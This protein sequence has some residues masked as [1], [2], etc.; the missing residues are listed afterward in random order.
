MSTTTTPEWPAAKVR[1]VFID[2]F[3]N[4]GHTFVPSSSTIPYEDPTLLFANAG[5]NQYKS[6]FLGTVDPNSDFAKLKRAV[7]SQKCIRA[8]GKH[9]DLEDVGKDT[10]HHTMFE[11]LGNW[12]FGDYFKK[13]AILW[14]WELLTEVYKLPKDRLYVTYFEGDAKQGL[15]PD[16]E[17]KQLW[18]DVGV[19][20][21]HILPGNA[22]D[23]FWEMGATGPCGPCSEI[24]Y[25]RIG[26]RNAGHLVNQDDPNVLEIWNNVFMEFNREDDGSLRPLPARHIDTGM[27]FERLVS[28][29]QDKYSN[30]DTDVFLPL[31]AKIQELTG[32][33]AYTGKLGAEDVDGID[34]AYRV[35][36]DHVRTLTFALAD[37]GV[38]SNV[39]RGYVLRRILRRGAR[40]VRKKFDVPIGSFFSSLMPAVIDQLGGFFPELNKRTED[41]KEILNEEEESFSRTLDRGEKLFERY[42][43]RAKE[44]GA[45][46]LSG[47]DVWRLYD[48]YGFP[49]DLTRLMAE[50]LGLGV[51]D[52]EFEAAQAHSKEASKATK[53]TG[54]KDV[55]KLDVHDIAALEKND[56]V[57]KTDDSHKFALGNVTARLKGIYHSKAFFTSTKEVPQDATFGLLLDRT[58]FYAES[59]GQ[60]YDTGSIVI[61]DVAEFEVENVQ[62]FNGY[63]LHIGHMKYGQLALEDEVVASYDEL[64]RWPLRNNHTATHILNYALREVLG[65]HVDQKGSLVAPS[66]LRFDFSHKAQITLPELTKIEEISNEWI[67]RNVKVYSKE[68]NLEVARKIPGLRAVFGEVYPDPVRVVTL[69]Y[70]V[71]DI[72][73]DVENPKWRNTSVE[74]CGGTHVAKTGDIKDFVITEE[75]G[76]AKGI[77]RLVAVTGAEAHDVTREASTFESRLSQ[78]ERLTGK[79]KDAGLKTLTADIL[80][81]EISVLRKADLKERLT[82][83][84]KAFD[85]ENKAVEVALTK[86][87]TEGLT[88]HF[89]ENPNSNSYISHVD[90]EGSPKI[91][92]SLVAQARTLQKAVF[93]FSVDSGAGKVAYLNYLPKTS[94]SKEFN[95]KSWA[96]SVADVLGGKGGG[97]D[98]SAQGVGTNIDK[99]S[100][101]IQKAEAAYKANVSS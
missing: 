10:Y 69:E 54:D 11:M 29:L 100:E 8:G 60:E 3:K 55:V 44:A 63:V 51:N 95:A 59:G 9:N 22:K 37:G 70:D 76:I 33:R 34:T 46:Q 82:K 30:Y 67:R 47:T 92:Q 89:T 93:L 28:A 38:P 57:P 48:T 45:T 39:G 79:E 84:R 24:H 58:S 27:G 101:A 88:K 75:S 31:F 23:N 19:P 66:K 86:A 62:V 81:A 78:V 17:A 68:L 71:E 64:R 94:I 53:K 18:L 56:N 2:F 21:D 36:A 91:L 65:D 96:T 43:T 74:F 14:A 7:N 85:A 42:A 35:V 1:Q 16:L 97:K 73:K 77:R 90:V 41:I 32:A 5:M 40:Y 25:D 13:E 15:S 61:D 50:E 4:K 52:K 12:S 72:A 99:V 20:E 6:I 49:V 83:V 26:G 98:D 80:G 87:A